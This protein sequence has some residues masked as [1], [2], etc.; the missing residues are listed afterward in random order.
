MPFIQFSFAILKSDFTKLADVQ[1]IQSGDG[2]LLG[3][4]ICHISEPTQETHWL[5]PNNEV[6]TMILL[7]K[8]LW[9]RVM[10]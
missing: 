6:Y 9:N 8:I 7:D 1:K 5:T 10:F 3:N 4:D 2:G